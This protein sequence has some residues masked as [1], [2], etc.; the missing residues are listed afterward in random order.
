MGVNHNESGGDRD[1]SSAAGTRRLERLR[2]RMRNLRENPRKPGAI[3]AWIRIL[4]AVASLVSGAA[5]FI[6]IMRPGSTE[7]GGAAFVALAGL[8]ALLAAIGRVPQ[9]VNAGSMA[10]EFA[11]VA[12]IVRAIEDLPSASRSEVAETLRN[13][14]ASTPA[15]RLASEMIQTGVELERL[16]LRRMAELGWIERHYPFGDRGFDAIATIGGNRYA[17][18]I[19]AM[20]M[21]S[22]LTQ[23]VRQLES[24]LAGQHDLAGGILVVAQLGHPSARARRVGRVLIV[25]VDE[26]DAIPEL[27]ET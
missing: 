9:K 23:A 1:P 14:P 22:A 10:V 5:G 26:I 24:V 18:E 19:K 7:V 6:A 4:L 20:R 25:S 11:E 21:T 15:Q 2:K 17:V 27:L 8:F 3:A 16:V 13:D 12:P